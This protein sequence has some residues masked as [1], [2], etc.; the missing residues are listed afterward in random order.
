[1][2]DEHERVLLDLV[3]SPPPGSA[4]ASYLTPLTGLTAERVAARGVPLASAVAAV[5]ASLPP[6]AVLVGQNILKDV[7]WLGLKEGAD[8]SGCVDLAGLY[9]VSN[10][11]FRGA[12]TIFSQDHLAKVLLAWPV[13]AEEAAEGDEEG[14]KEGGKGEGGGDGGDGGAPATANKAA[15]ASDAAPPAPAPSAAPT[16]LAHD[17]ALDAIKSVRLFNLHRRVLA[18]DPA[19]AWADAQRRLLE[20]K[21]TPSFA[22]RHP[23]WEGV[24]MGNRR[25]CTC[26]GPFFS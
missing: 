22:T 25:T 6:T 8:F 11:R 17:A 23:Q 14:G 4:V 18:P 10:P 16:P 2:V 13:T 21:A 15:A 12:F 3:V 19:G 26:G 7:H 9:R 1:L 24:C 5:R 20:A